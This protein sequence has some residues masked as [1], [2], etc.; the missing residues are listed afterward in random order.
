[1]IS[2]GLTS[3]T[4]AK[5]F[6]M[7]GEHTH[8]GCCFRRPRR[9]FFLYDS[10][11]VRRG[12]ERSTRGRVRSPDSCFRLPSLQNF[13]FSFG[14]QTRAHF[15][16]SILRERFEPGERVARCVSER[17]EC[18]AFAQGSIDLRP[19]E[20][21]LVASPNRHVRP[22]LD[23][24]LLKKLVRQPGETRV[25]LQCA[26]NTIEHGGNAERRRRAGR[27]INSGLAVLSHSNRP[28]G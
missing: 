5:S 18:Q 12:A 27:V 6:F 16:L 14:R 28:L 10:D 26:F 2:F 1:R 21:E 13:R 20:S 22:G 24:L 9:K 23:L 4:L 8:L 17:P 15:R 7:F 11:F 3:T 19:R 25:R